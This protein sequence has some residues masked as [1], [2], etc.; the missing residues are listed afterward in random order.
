MSLLLEPPT[1]TLRSQFPTSHSQLMERRFYWVSLQLRRI[2]DQTHVSGIKKVLVDIPSEVGGIVKGALD[3]INMQDPNR[4]RLAT[5][6][7][8]LLTAAKAPMTARALSHAMGISHVLDPKRRLSELSEDEIPNPASI[9][10]CCMGLVAIDPV[11]KV[12]MLAHFDIAQYMQTHWKELFSWKEQL[13]LANTTLSY[14]SLQVFSPGPC[15]QVGRFA[16][17]LEEYPFLDYASR[18]WGLHAREAMLLQEAAAEEG[19]QKLIENVNSFL[20]NRMNLEFS[21]QVCD[22]RSKPLRAREVLFEK[23][24]ALHADKFRSVSE[25]QVATRHGF[26]AIAERILKTCPAMVSYQDDFGMSALHEAAQAGWYDLVDMLLKAGAQPSPRNKEEKA[27]VYYAAKNGYTGIIQ[28]ISKEESGNEVLSEHSR[29]S[30]LT[31]GRNETVPMRKD[32]GDPLALEEAFCDAAEAGRLDV[33]RLLL[34]Y[35]IGLADSKKHEKTAMIFAIHGG[36]EKI[37]EMLLDANACHS[38][39]DYTP[40]DQIPL[41]LAVRYSNENMVSILLERGA[42]VETCD[43]LGRTALFETLDCHD[44]HTATLLFDAGINISSSDREGNTVLHEAVRRGAVEHA[45]LLIDQ[46]IQ[47]NDFNTEGLTPL[48]LAAR[49]GHCRIANDLLKSAADVDVVDQILEWTP[50]MYGA[51]TGATQLCQI[52]LSCGANVA[53]VSSEHETPLLIAANAGNHQV[54]HLLLD[55]GADVNGL[56]TESKTPLL[57]AAAAGDAQLVRLLLQYGADVN[58][59][60]NRSNSSLGLAADAGHVSIAQLLLEKGA[61]PYGIKWEPKGPAG[62]ATGTSNRLIWQM[63]HEYGM[64]VDAIKKI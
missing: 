45:S 52:L 54:A 46:G 42:D 11:T 58:V 19:K 21:L 12:V 43:E 18:H 55:Y 24:F 63:L 22:L 60:D 15:H 62:K 20:H 39:E 2:L 31:S 47:V 9:I 25:L 64:E 50:L 56:D 61:N 44:L 33:I 41:H 49:H 23:D 36:H 48:H 8:A 3:M 37:L 32:Q 57:L 40:S 34:E 4:T 59:L 27:P 6:T 16:R 17:L 38:S 5:R 51:S 7:L 29:S 10:E 35:D 28:L 14:L 53:M 13:L 1:P 26:S 30:D